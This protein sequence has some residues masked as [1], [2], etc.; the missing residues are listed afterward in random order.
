MRLSFFLFLFFFSQTLWAFKLDLYAKTQLKPG[1][2]YEKQLIGGIS[3]IAFGDQKLWI[4]SDDK[5]RMGEPRF[6]EMDLKISGKTVSLTPRAVFLVRGLPQRTEKTGGLDL[7]AIVLLN[8]GQF[9]IASEGNNNA[10]PREMPGIFRVSSKGLWQNNLPLDDRY[11]PEL[12]GQQ[13]KGVQNNFAFE[14][15]TLAI[16]GKSLFTATERPLVQDDALIR[17]LKYSDKGGKNFEAVAEYAYQVESLGEGEVF[18]GVSEMLAVS[19]KRILIL[20][21]GALLTTKGLA[22]S[23]GLYLVDLDKATDVKKIEKLSS[24]GIKIAEKKK[25]W[26]FGVDVPNFEALS[27]GPLLEDGRKSLLVMSDDN[28]SKDEVTELVIFAVEGE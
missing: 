16:D 12:T 15:L 5:G 21:R 28:F 17:I 7:E 1:T 20:E 25:I 10:K 24:K 9:L 18:R 26:D 3:G 11:L 19:D 14:S 23:A 22:Y 2:R 13:R 4:L 6:F 27:W 8:D